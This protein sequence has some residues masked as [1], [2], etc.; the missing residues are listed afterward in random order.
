MVVVQLAER[1]L[2]ILE[3]HGLNPV[4][5]KN[6]YLTCL[7][8]VNCTKDDNKENEAENGQFLIIELELTT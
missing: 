8:T 4:I 3:I 1:S 5:G 7:P 6:L 2:P